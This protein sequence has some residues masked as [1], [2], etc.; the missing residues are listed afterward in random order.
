[1]AAM[2][3]TV[4]IMN[5]LVLIGIS[6]QMYLAAKSR[7]RIEEMLEQISGKIPDHDLDGF[8]HQ[9]AEDC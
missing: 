4:T 9:S 7:Y 6:V 5:A 1:M 3:T 2:V 8:G